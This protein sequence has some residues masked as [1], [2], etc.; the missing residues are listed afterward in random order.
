MSSPWS[1]HLK[2]KFGTLDAAAL[3]QLETM[4]QNF[5]T[6]MIAN[7]P[8]D[9][10]EE[11]YLIKTR[12]AVNQLIHSLVL[13]PE[14]KSPKVYF[15]LEGRELDFVLGENVYSTTPRLLIKVP[16]AREDGATGFIKIDPVGEAVAANVVQAKI[17]DKTV[18]VIP[19]QEGGQEKLEDR[20][21]VQETALTPGEYVIWGGL[22]LADRKA[23]YDIVEKTMNPPEGKNAFQYY[24]EAGTVEDL[25][26]IVK[27]VQ[28]LGF[29]NMYNSHEKYRTTSVQPLP[30][31]E[32][33]KLETGAVSGFYEKPAN[34]V[35]SS[36]I[37]LPGPIVFLGRGRAEETLPNNGY[38]VYEQVAGAEEYSIRP[39]SPS[40]IK[41]NFVYRRSR[42]NVDQK[43][44]AG[45][46][47]IM[48]VPDHPLRDFVREFTSFQ[49]SLSEFNHGARPQPK[50]A[51]DFN[52]KVG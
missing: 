50:A 17:T 48:F 20:L 5:E 30:A 52:T 31:H 51:N 32:A 3:S 8:K 24:D 15:R 22:K 6:A 35:S 40:Y 21:L 38:A 28:A 14:S 9:R 19:N 10:S 7:K 27:G 41:E 23:V 47:Q 12:R 42:E 2:A 34:A 26:K 44:G 1:S 11:T 39:L 4:V 18:I 25:A 37:F 46:A 13:D 49:Y 45:L 33:L 36:A 29:G 16:A 43:P